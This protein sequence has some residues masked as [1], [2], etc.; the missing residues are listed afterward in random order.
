MTLP[1]LFDFFLASHATALGRLNG[2][3]DPGG[4]SPDNQHV[5]RF[6]RRHGRTGHLF[7]QRFASRVIDDEEYLYDA[8]EYILQNPVR[9]GICND[10]SDYPWARSDL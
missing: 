3:C 7:G 9:A 10:P 8:S 5:C 2:R 6:N 4:A 1:K